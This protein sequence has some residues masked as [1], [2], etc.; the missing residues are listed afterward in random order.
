MSFIEKYAAEFSAP[1]LERVSAIVK[2]TAA[3]GLDDP[4]PTN[5]VDGSLCLQWGTTCFVSVWEDSLLIETP[6]VCWESDYK[7][8]YAEIADKIKAL[9]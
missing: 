4:N 5:G 7:E 6:Q 9:V 2:A 3:A 8:S 1:V